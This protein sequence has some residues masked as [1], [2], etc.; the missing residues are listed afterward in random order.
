VKA[1]LKS[2]VA[3]AATLAIAG[4][5]LIASVSTPASAAGATAPAWEPD[6]IGN[7]A[8]Y[9]GL[10]F[11]DTNGNIATSG[12]SLTNLFAY[13]VGDSPFNT[14]GTNHAT[15][16]ELSF[17]TPS[18]TK[19]TDSW[20]ASPQT[21][22][23][24]FPIT[25]GA[26][27]NIMG[28]TTTPVYN[29]IASGSDLKDSLGTPDTTSG[30]V[31]LAQVRLF[32][33]GIQNGTSSGSNYWEAD[34][35]YNTGT[36]SAPV[37]VNAAAGYSVNV[38]AG[39]WVQVYPF[40]IPTTTTLNVAPTSSPQPTGTQFSLTGTVSPAEN[41][42]VTFFNGT[43][44]VGT[45]QPVS[46]S[47]GT[48]A[49]AV[50]DTPANGTA[51]Y[52]AVFNPTVGQDQNQNSASPANESTVLSST[53]STQ[54][55]SVLIPT[56]NTVAAPSP[57]TFGSSEQL[58]DTVSE[59]DG[60]TAGLTGTV[61]FFNNGSALNAG[62]PAAT[63][64][65]GVATLTT[66]TLP[67]TSGSDVDNITA[68]FSPTDTSYSGGTSSNSVPVTVNA[69]PV[70]SND[71]FAV[72]P[73]T[74]QQQE[75]KSSCTD[76]QNIQVTVEPGTLTITTPYTQASPFVLP[77]LSLSSDGTYLQ[78]SAAFPT[79]PTG[80]NQP[81][82]ANEI[83]VTSTLAGDPGWTMSVAASSLTNGTGGSIPASG[84]GLTGGTLINSGTFPGTVNF[85]AGGIP[86]HNP[87]PVDADTNNGLESS[88]Q[89]WATSPAGAGTALMH[90]QL[91]LFAATNIP[92]GTYSGTITFSVI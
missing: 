30:Y 19:T 69:P 37:V 81:T 13:A 3:G 72:N 55:V 79:Q 87:S 32:D 61:I 50:T 73:A 86:A 4:A 8:P 92:Q 38:P 29:G 10:T 88:G 36:T 40:T 52:S 5:G 22:G 2:A 14:S 80:T 6:T 17:A 58:T 25:T 34:V 9:G 64:A 84:L 78:S 49:T 42:T 71:Y 83:A 60:V 7:P 11:Y 28:D 48:T 26:P 91:T 54:T 70:C 43:T 45:P 75:Y 65:S 47:S 51:S 66:S 21:A 20:F 62:S 23:T 77:D 63:D 27:T 67:V 15:K 89:T 53:S 74:G 85:T 44:Q 57:I 12:S 59:T 41:G 68:V 76:V 35:A 90:G 31:S 56:T 16:A 18:S 39:G 24:V 46:T 1:I 82:S 33:T